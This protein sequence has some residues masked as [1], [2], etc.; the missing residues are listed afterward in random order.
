MAAGGSG[1]A[2]GR[3]VRQPGCTANVSTSARSTGRAGLQ[4]SAPGSM[5]LS[6]PSRIGPPSAPTTPQR[7]GAAAGGG[8]A[9]L[10]QHETPSDRSAERAVR[11]GRLRE[12]RRLRPL[13]ARNRAHRRQAASPLQRFHEGQQARVGPQWSAPP[14]RL[15]RILAAAAAAAPPARNPRR[16]R[17]PLLSSCHPCGTPYCQGV[18]Q[19]A[20]LPLPPRGAVLGAA[21][22][23][24]LAPARGAAGGAAAE[25]RAAHL[26]ALAHG[27][28]PS[29]G[30]APEPARGGA[31]APAQRRGGGGSAVA[32]G[33]GGGGHH[34]S[35]RV[36]CSNGG[37]R[38]R[39]RRGAA[40]GSS[41][42]AGGGAGGRGWRAGSARELGREWGARADP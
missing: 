4:V 20:G 36:R 42:A 13:S 23:R 6:C 41:G 14:T 19:G 39:R 40:C 29:G 26:A 10:A 35:C 16:R 1:A 37:R 33:G 28:Q 27:C 18:A 15:A 17:S 2:A 5:E 3:D 25:R 11:L 32:H 38:Q 22:G 24:L 31:Q 34:G 7:P 9:R 30:G 12:G 21:A 8:R